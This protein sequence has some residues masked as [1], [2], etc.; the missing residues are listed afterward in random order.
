M[1]KLVTFVLRLWVDPQAEQPTWEGQAE[2]VGSGERAHVRGAEQVVRFLE[3]Q[4]SEGGE[5]R[6]QS[7]ARRNG[8]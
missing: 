1:R 8:P 2:C 7:E 5:T 4:I 6:A 3:A